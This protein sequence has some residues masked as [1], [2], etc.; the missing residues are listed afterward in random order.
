[1]IR[2]LALA[3]LAALLLAAPS[4]ADTFQLTLLSQGLCWGI[5]GLSVWLLLLITS[6]FTRAVR[7]RVRSS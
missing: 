1:M 2:Y 7:S 4:P 6:S 3:V 5:L